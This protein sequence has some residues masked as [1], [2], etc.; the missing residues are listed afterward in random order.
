MSVMKEFHRAF[1]AA[2]IK[3][4][5]TVKSSNNSSDWKVR[6]SPR[7]ARSSGDFPSRSTPSN[8]TVPADSGVNPVMASMNVVLPAPFGPINPTSLP[9]VMSMST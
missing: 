6:V 9:S 3:L 2:A 8:V 4:S 5:R 1:S 7:C